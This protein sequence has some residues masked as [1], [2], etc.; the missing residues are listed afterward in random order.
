MN[1]W[2]DSRFQPLLTSSIWLSKYKSIKKK[3]NL[4]YF[5]DEKYQHLL[6]PTIFVIPIQNIV[7]NI[8][9]FEEF[10]IERFITANS[11]RRGINVQRALF[12]YLTSN[13]I[14]FVIDGKLNP[15][16][17]ASTKKLKDVYG[18]VLK[19]LMKSKKVN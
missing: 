13:N 18:I 3:L 17:N 12:E 4:S 1:E 16:L 19:D 5:Q 9:L 15:K 7:D 14:D 11:L 2:N 8:Q 6:T 10:G